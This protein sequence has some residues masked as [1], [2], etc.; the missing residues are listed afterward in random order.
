MVQIGTAPMQR[1]GTMPSQPIQPTGSVGA[2]LYNG[3]SFSSL[4]NIEK[5]DAIREALGDVNRV[6]G[7]AALAAGFAAGPEAAAAVA[8]GV[9]AVN[10]IG[11]V[12]ARTLEYIG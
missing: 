11:T 4:N 9:A 8:G 5:A 1:A 12:A 3:R 10:V 7:A 2:G 6:G